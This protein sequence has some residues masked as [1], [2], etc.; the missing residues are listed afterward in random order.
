MILNFLP[1]IFFHSDQ[2]RSSKVERDLIR[3]EAAIGGKLFGPIPKGHRRDFFCLDE[4]TWIWHEE[5]V[6]KRGQ[7]R[8]VTTRYDVRPSGVIKVQDGQAYQ[9]LSDNE[10]SNLYHAT[11]LYR[12]RV[13]AEYQRILQAA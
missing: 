4:H 7:R 10:A 11:Q 3:R 13:G 12:Q 6:D 9:K 1:K 5:W 8:A 2:E